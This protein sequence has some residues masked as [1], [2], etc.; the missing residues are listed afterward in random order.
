VTRL[1]G[2]L[3]IVTVHQSIPVVRSSES[4]AP[5]AIGRPPRLHAASG[6]NTCDRIGRDTV[7]VELGVLFGGKASA[8]WVLTRE[9]Q[10]VDARKDDEKAAEQRNGVD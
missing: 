9:V 6:A 7:V 8:F 5:G 4:E 2:C 10:E 1:P 3:Q